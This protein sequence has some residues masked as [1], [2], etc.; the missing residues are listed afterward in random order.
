MLFLQ[1]NIHR[2]WRYFYRH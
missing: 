2:R 1:K